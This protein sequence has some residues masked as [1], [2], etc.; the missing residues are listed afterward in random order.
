MASG[1]PLMAYVNAQKEDLGV[2][3][4]LKFDVSIPRWRG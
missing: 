1:S 3:K 2:H 4:D